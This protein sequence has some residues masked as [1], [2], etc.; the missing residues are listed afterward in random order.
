MIANTKRNTLFATT[1]ALGLLG[2]L[3]LP[4]AMAQSEH[5]GHHPQT[6]QAA[7]K[8]GPAT[9]GQGQMPQ[10]GMMDHSQMNQGQ[11][12]DHGSMDHGQTMQQMHDQ[13]MNHGQ[14]DHGN[15][16]QG[17]MNHGSTPPAKAAPKTKDGKDG[18]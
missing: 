12:M 11:M 16:G 6:A 8:Q 5:D 13:H 7:G 14:M 17:Q 4:Q 3:Q 10:G 2:A 15:M 9:M 1:L 18:Q